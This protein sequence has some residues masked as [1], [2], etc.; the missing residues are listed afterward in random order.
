VSQTGY[1]PTRLGGEEGQAD[2]KQAREDYRRAM[3]A[4]LEARGYSVK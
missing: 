3:G 1:D 4:C 2:K